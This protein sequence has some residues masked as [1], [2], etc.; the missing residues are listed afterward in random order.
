ME[1]R[2]TSEPSL[3]RFSHVQLNYA[4]ISWPEDTHCPNTDATE[5]TGTGRALRWSFLFLSNFLIQVKKKKKKTSYSVFSFSHRSR[6]EQSTRLPS[7]RR[8]TLSAT[9]VLFQV[10]ERSRK[11][12][13]RLTAS[14]F[15]LNDH[16]RRA[17]SD[18]SCARQIPLTSH[19]YPLY[20]TC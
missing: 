20:N 17:R 3:I 8:W 13:V 4:A 9:S 11:Q 16:Y 5:G 7:L 19:I 10:P 6:S 1:S 2:S 18:K 15:G 14:G 12:T